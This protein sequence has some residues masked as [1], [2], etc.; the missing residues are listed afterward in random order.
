M[1]TMLL[2]T[3]P[4]TPASNVNVSIRE[5]NQKLIPY[6]TAAIAPATAPKVVAKR[7]PPIL[8]STLLIPIRR[9]TA[10]PYENK[11][12]KKRRITKAPTNRYSKTKSSVNRRR[13]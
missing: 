10:E 2:I 7:L 3:N 6:Q 1:I 13:K 8:V 9:F 12:Q 4:K 11:V 5:G